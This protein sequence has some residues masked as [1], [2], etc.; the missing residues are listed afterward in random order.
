MTTQT[1]YLRWRRWLGVPIPTN[2][3]TLDG[4]TFYDNL[5]AIPGPNREWSFCQWD[6]SP[7]DL[8]PAIR[9]VQDTT[10]KLYDNP[11]YNRFYNMILDPE[12]LNPIPDS[13]MKASEIEVKQNF[14]SILQAM[15]K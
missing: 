11:N 14:K 10:Y 7:L 8:K 4:V 15:H 2:Y 5:L 9:Y 12:E 1:F 3:G 6:N 13:D